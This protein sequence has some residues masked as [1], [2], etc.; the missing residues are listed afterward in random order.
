MHPREKIVSSLIELLPLSRL[1]RSVGEKIVLT[2]GCFDLLHGG[3]LE[4]ICTAG[5]MG[6][7]VVG[8]NNDQFVK[9][10]KGDSR[11]IRNENDRAFTMAGF[12]SVGLV[13]IFDDDCELIQAV[14]PD[15]YVAS[16]TSHVRVRED[17][18]RMGLLE[19]LGTTIVELQSEKQDST[20]EMIMRVSV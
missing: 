4:Y 10:L 15:I 20:T 6:F 14:R 1:R 16:S 11:P 5:D 13:A 12:Y 18:L 3:H 7:L 8:I 2:S 19:S 17:L 9:R